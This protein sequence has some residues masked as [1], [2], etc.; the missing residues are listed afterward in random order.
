MKV[1][2]VSAIVAASCFSILALAARFKRKKPIPIHRLVPSDD[3][4]IWHHEASFDEGKTW[5]P[6][7]MKLRVIM[8][9]R[10]TGRIRY[11]DNVEGVK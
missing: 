5:V 2:F 9:K 3:P 7:R 1:V 4:Y 11:I 8:P 10:W 6:M